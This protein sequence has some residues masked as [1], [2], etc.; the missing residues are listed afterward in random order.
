MRW[1]AGG[2]RDTGHDCGSVK[3]NRL[4]V[5]FEESLQG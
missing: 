3:G 5:L 1:K 4:G 2:P